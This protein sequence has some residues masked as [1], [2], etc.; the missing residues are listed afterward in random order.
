[1]PPWPA[2]QVWQSRSC[3]AAPRASLAMLRS[4]RKVLGNIRMQ[5]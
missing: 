3:S 1:M 5:L 4:D 2:H